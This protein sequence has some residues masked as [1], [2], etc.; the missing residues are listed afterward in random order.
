MGTGAAERGGVTSLEVRRLLP[1][2]AEEVF[3]AWTD[4]EVMRTWLSPVGHADVEVDLRIGGRFRVTMVGEDRRIEHTGEYL[5][6]A[7]PRRLAFTWSSR[8][9]GPEPG[10]VTVELRPA[11]GG[12][13]LVLT[14]ERLPEGQVEPH[15]GGWG[16]MLDRLAEEVLA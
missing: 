6:I 4:P 16:R 7:P 13:E 2:S 11:E 8:F 1:A 14:H 3:A 5:E 10:V 12:T 15:Q 9:T